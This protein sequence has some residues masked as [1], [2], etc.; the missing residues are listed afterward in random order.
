M[1][2][3]DEPARV[4]ASDTRAANRWK[5]VAAVLAVVVVTLAVILMISTGLLGGPNDVE[6]IATDFQEAWSALD[7]DAVAAFFPEDGKIEFLEYGRTI[8]GPEAIRESVN[9][10]PSA[11]TSVLQFG[12]SVTDGRFV[13]TPFTWTLT[14]SGSV[15]YSGISIVKVVGDQVVVQYI[16][17]RSR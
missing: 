14:G 3:T 1:T 10:S 5:M 15:N 9:S 4:S 7:G 6:A 12:D 13:A 8:V 16:V 2:H 17:D 11:N